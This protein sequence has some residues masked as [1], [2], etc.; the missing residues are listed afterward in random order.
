M[1]KVTICPDVKIKPSVFIIFEFPV[2]ADVA[3]N[4]FVLIGT[5]N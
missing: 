4:L 1:T 5:I 2:V 3:S